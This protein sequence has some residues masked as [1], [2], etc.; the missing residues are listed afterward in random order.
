L[1]NCFFSVQLKIFNVCNWPKLIIRQFQKTNPD[2]CHSILYGFDEAKVAAQPLDTIESK[3]PIGR[4]TTERRQLM[5]KK[6]PN[7]D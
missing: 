4:Q 3:F 5:L 2:S 7:L 1:N 6:S